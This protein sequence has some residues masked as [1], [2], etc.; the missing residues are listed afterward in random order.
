MINI[1]IKDILNAVNGR[2]IYGN[3]DVFINGISTDSRTAK[4]GELFFALKGP[5]FDGHR[6]VDEAL[7]KGAAGAVV[8][9]AGNQ[10]PADR[11]LIQVEDTLTA[12]GDIARYWRRLHPVPLIA[13]SGSCGKTTTKEMIASILNT[14]RTIIKTEGNLNNLIGLPLT[15]FGLNNIHKA[16]VVE[17]GISEKGEMKRLADICRPDVA[18]LTNIGEAHTATLG[19]IEDVAAAK[20]ELFNSMGNNA[21]AVINMD[22]PWL[23]KMA[24]HIRAKKI[25]F[26]IQSKADVMLIDGNQWSRVKGHP[27]QAEA[28]FMVMGEKI[29]VRLKYTGAHNLSN[30]AAAIAATIPLGA[31]KEEIRNGLHSVEPLHGRLE[32]IAVK[33]GI[34]VI[35]DTYNANPSSM[36]AS[37][38]TLSATNGRKIAVLGDMLELGDI[39]Q[40]AHKKIGR[41]AK[42]A[43]V[44]FLFII[45]NFRKDVL[46]GAMDAGMAAERL[47]EAENKAVLMETLNGIIKQGDTILVKGSRGMKME[48]VVEGL[49]S[50]VRSQKSE[51]KNF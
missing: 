20:G 15:L 42:E 4:Q 16:A 43:D 11:N 29:P 34:T 39:A 9:K 1:K 18:V 41:L 19:S 50:K 32:V 12:L 33:N 21:T 6:F 14:S 45:G 10:K 36:E 7:K 37:L 26:S 24:A 46:I 17:L 25:T 38:K 44:D 30:A 5:N 47:Y 48:E 23:S 49:K 8:S 35:D 31:T 27:S 28:T 51:D 40:A 2:L 3:G 22:D 13:V